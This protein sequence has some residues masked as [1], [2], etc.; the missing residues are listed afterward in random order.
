MSGTSSP[1]LVAVSAAVIFAG[2]RLGH[3]K[4]R[5]ISKQFLA[6]HPMRQLCTCT[7]SDR[8]YLRRTL[9]IRLY[10]LTCKTTFDRRKTQWQS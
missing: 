5:D 6:E 8:A 2:I 9:Q 10:I 4:A 1:I 7:A 3:K